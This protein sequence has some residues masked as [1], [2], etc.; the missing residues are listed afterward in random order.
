[1][2]PPLNWILSLLLISIS[3]ILYAQSIKFSPKKPSPGDKVTI[4]YKPKGGELEGKKL[5]C[6]YALVGKTK[7]SHDILELGEERVSYSFEV[8]TPDSALALAIL[9]HEEFAEGGG[10]AYENYY[11]P[12]VDKESKKVLRGAYGAL[13]EHVGIR[14]YTPQE[15]LY[16]GKDFIEKEWAIW[17]E[18]SSQYWF[19][20]SLIA[21]NGNL[22]TAKEKAEAH[23]KGVLQNKEAT[24]E[25][26]N[27]LYR[28]TMVTDTVG[29]MMD[30]I[31]TMICD[32]F[33]VGEVAAEIASRELYNLAD[34]VEQEA[35]FSDYSRKFAE[36]KFSTLSLPNMASHMA[37]G[38]VYQ[39]RWE[40]VE[41]YLDLISPKYSKAQTLNQIVR[42]MVGDEL[43]GFHWDLDR[44]MEYA[45]RSLKLIEKEIA[46]QEED[47]FNKSGPLVSHE[48][49]YT[50]Y[51]DTY[52]LVNYKKGNK[53]KA[54][55]IQQEAMDKSLYPDPAML[56]RY[57]VY[58]QEDKSPSE[59]IGLIEQRI[60]AGEQTTTMMEL[61]K[62]LMFESMSV[63]DIYQRY[64]GMLSKERLKSEMMD[65][66][67][68]LF[69]LTDLE[70]EMVSLEELRGK[71]VVLDFWA[72]WCAP[73]IA[74][75]PGMNKAREKYAD[76]EDV[77]FLF[78][79]TWERVDDP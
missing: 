12:F 26:L 49:V 53:A 37:I 11:L 24:E 42:I 7:S 66:E 16:K 41:E 1:M 40:K 55:E 4:T 68:P 19:S 34:M 61:H 58:L 32:R 70:G 69:T 64:M 22:P 38:F 14:I 63:N 76:N 62:K 20:Y 71:V 39:Q 67:A 77:V 54:L 51:L 29:T 2:K 44:A 74:S 23:M 46:T 78:L 8:E 73:C 45:E 47:S 27:E 43:D 30:S 72:T 13:G 15:E 5:T 31:S 9:F 79:N 21:R 17:P 25:E 33:P 28:V 57:F 52:A 6:S 50:Q 60:I 3:P 48:T 65:R 59:M 18:S 10:L 36:T 35:Y 75:F 56:D